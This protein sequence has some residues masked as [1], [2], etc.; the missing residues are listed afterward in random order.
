MSAWRDSV[1]ARACR[2]NRFGRRSCRAACANRRPYSRIRRASHYGACATSSVHWKERVPRTCR[3]ASGGNSVAT[4]C[5]FD[6]ERPKAAVPVQTW[7]GQMPR[8]P[9][10]APHSKAS[11]ATTRR[12]DNDDIPFRYNQA[13]G[14]AEQ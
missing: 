5:R 10:R 3:P 9:V 14:R 6:A 7:H 2:W 4:S 11:R 8:T 12:L 1:S 13:I